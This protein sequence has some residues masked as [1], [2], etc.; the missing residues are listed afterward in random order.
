MLIYLRNRDRE[1]PYWHFAEEFP[2]RVRVAL[3]QLANGGKPWLTNLEYAR[4]VWDE[5]RADYPADDMPIDVV[6]L[7]GQ[8]VALT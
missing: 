2:K 5:L 8:P 3:S 7:D 1:H 6:D 4:M